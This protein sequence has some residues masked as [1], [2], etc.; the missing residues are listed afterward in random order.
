M[1]Y[2]FLGS[3][4]YTS[5]DGQPVQTQYTADQFG[6]HATGSHIPQVKFHTIQF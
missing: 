1:F 2:S 3:F 6:Y 5:P 4:Q